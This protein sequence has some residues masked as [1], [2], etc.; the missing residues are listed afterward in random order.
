MSVHFDG[1]NLHFTF[2][3]PQ[4][5]SGP[6]GEVTQSAQEAAIATTSSNSNNMG[7]LG[8]VVSD[9]PT[10]TEMQTLPNKVDELLL[11][12]RRCTPRVA[13]SV[14]F[15]RWRQT[16]ASSCLLAPSQTLYCCIIHGLQRFIGDVSPH[17]APR[18]V[19]L[20]HQESEMTKDGLH[21]EL[22]LTPGA[23][24]SHAFGSTPVSLRMERICLRSDS[25]R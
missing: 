20:E 3:L 19:M 17:N 5:Q 2:S 9:P 8:F 25:P 7:T 12:L 11:A 24:I 16:D 4:G 15:W 21:R 10:Q 18:I 14:S 6:P 13:E 23:G 1:T 22:H